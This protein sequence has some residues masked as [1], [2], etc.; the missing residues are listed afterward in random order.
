MML[1]VQKKTADKEER[2]TRRIEKR[3]NRIERIE[4]MQSQIRKLTESM[5]EKLKKTREEIKKT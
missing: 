5:D 4:R 1:V 2:I 3:M